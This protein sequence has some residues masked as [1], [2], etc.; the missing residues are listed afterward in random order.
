[1]SRESTDVRLEKRKSSP[2][3]WQSWALTTRYLI[4]KLARTIPT[5]IVMWLTYMHR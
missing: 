2:K 3:P 4:V 1:M 5:A